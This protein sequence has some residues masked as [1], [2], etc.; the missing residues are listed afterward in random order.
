MSYGDK[1]A[2]R[3]G[4]MTRAGRAEYAYRRLEEGDQVETPDG[5]VGFISEKDPDGMHVWV[6]SWERQGKYRASEVTESGSVTGGL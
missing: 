4:E 1:E 3:Q 6:E 5:W 2:W